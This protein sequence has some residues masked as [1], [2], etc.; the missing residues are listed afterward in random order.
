[1]VAGDLGANCLAKVHSTHDTRVSHGVLWCFRCGAYSAG[2][3]RNLTKEC[4]G[5]PDSIAHLQ[6]LREG[7]LPE[8]YEYEQDDYYALLKEEP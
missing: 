1:M 3:W 4:S 6:K 5:K 8:A 2:S 7:N